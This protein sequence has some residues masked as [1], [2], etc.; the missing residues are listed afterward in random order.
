MSVMNYKGFSATVEF[1][2]DDLILV[3]RLT[4]INDVVGFHADSGPALVDAFHEAV[5]DYIETAARLGKK[6]AK[7]YSGKLMLRVD[8]SVHAQAAHAAE[9]DGKS[10]NSWSEAVLRE[11]AEKRVGE[12][13]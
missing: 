6:R 12:H 9:V 10:L 5:D 2:P 11:A 4:G 13:A 3:G 1:D 7:P 8:P